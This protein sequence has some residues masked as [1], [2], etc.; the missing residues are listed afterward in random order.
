MM[1]PKWVE[2]LAEFESFTAAE[3]VSVKRKFTGQGD[4]GPDLIVKLSKRKGVTVTRVGWKP[5]RYRARLYQVT[6]DPVT[7][8]P[9]VFEP[10]RRGAQYARKFEAG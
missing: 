9:L 7:D 6:L 3:A 1:I 10:E 4:Y 2:I 5:G 8:L